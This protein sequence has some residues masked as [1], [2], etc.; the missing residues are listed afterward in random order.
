MQVLFIKRHVTD[1]IVKL[2]WIFKLHVSKDFSCNYVLQRV[3][4]LQMIDKWLYNY[5]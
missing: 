1:V 5:K 3:V 2:E 4:V